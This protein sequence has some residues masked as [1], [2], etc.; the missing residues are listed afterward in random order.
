MKNLNQKTINKIL[1]V[2]L[3]VLVIFIAQQKITEQ[4]RVEY[5]IC[6]EQ[7]VSGGGSSIEFAKDY[8]NG[9]YD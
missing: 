8:C 1:T 3:I 4:K 2:I 9:L 5:Y 7:V 6:Y